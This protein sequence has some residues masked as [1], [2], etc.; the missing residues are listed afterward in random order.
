MEVMHSRLGGD[1]EVRSELV[2][3]GLRLEVEDLDARLRGR[4]QPVAV[5]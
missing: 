5:R 1:V 4:A 3:N 2:N